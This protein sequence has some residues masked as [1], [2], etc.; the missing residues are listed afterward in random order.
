MIILAAKMKCIILHNLL[1][2]IFGILTML[3]GTSFCYGQNAVVQSESMNYIYNELPKIFLPSPQAMAFMRYGEIPI[4]LSAGVP[5]ITVPIYTIQANEEEIPITISY[6]ASGIKVKDVA[7]PVGLGWVLNA[8]GIMA[9]TVYSWND[10]DTHHN[11]HNISFTSA[12]EARKVLDAERIANMSS[13]N[14]NHMWIGCAFGYAPFFDQV[15]SH[16][17]QYNTISD[18]YY[19]NFNGCM[20]VFRFNIATK[21]YEILSSLPLNVEQI[22][23]GYGYIITDEKGIQWIFSRRTITRDS[24]SSGL[25]ITAMEYYLTYIKFPGKTDMVTFHYNNGQSYDMQYLTESVFTGQAVDFEVTQAGFTNTATPKPDRLYCNSR[26]IERRTANFTP[27]LLSEITWKDT[28]I[29]F[30]YESD[31]PDPMKERLTEISVTSG[32]NEIRKVRF[33]HE[34]N[35]ERTFLDSLIINKDETYAFQYNNRA[36]PSYKVNVSNPVF[37]E[38]FWGYF[39]GTNSKELV[40]FK[41]E[42]TYDHSSVTSKRVYL[43][44]KEANSTYSQAGILT[45]ITY[46][47]KGRTFFEYEQNRGRNVLKNMKPGQPEI[48]YFGGLRIKKITNY[49]NHGN[50]QWKSYEYEGGPTVTLTPDHYCV[51]KD[52]YYIPKLNQSLIDDKKKVRRNEVGTSITG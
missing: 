37:S 48:D 16:P 43:S 45:A 14:I 31:R 51:N 38:D 20:G 11:L 36:L 2:A 17:E 18:R 4:S 1:G 9:Q 10:E 49:D 5:E 29:T 12:D 19:F 7:G 42:C 39:N 3:Y 6:H 34:F 27:V 22:N 32:S 40:P 8:G 26:K 30:H 50:I 44:V 35:S 41:W 25:P 46:P 24:Y 28:K 13:G 33:F 15:P 23:D 21:K 47:T 52:F